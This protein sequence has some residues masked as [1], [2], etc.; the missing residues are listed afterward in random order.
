MI[1]S[2]NPIDALSQTFTRP[3]P[4]IMTGIDAANAVGFYTTG[5]NL[6]PYGGMSRP[7]YLE[8]R[9]GA[10]ARGFGDLVGEIGY[11]GLNRFGGPFRN[12]LTV[13][14]NEIPLIAPEGRLIGTDVAIGTRNR[15]PQGSARTQGIYAEPRLNPTVARV[16]AIL[17]SLG[18]PAPIFDTEKAYAQGET[19][20]A[21]DEKARLRRSLARLQSVQ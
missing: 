12:A 21:K 2:R 10:S 6:I 13:L 1:F 19:Q 7:G 18:I 4:I 16:G 5:K 8:G 9:P 17:A 20:A 11:M 14:P 3:S 15:Y